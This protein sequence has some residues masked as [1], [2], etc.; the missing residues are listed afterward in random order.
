MLN[1]SVDMRAFGCILFDS[2]TRRSIFRGYPDV[3]GVNPV[4]FMSTEV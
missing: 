3:K 1:T 4:E 2:V